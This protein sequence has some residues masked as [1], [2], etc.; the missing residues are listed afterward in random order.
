MVSPVWKG[1]DDFI[2]LLGA[3]ERQLLHDGL[4]RT[5]N[6]STAAIQEDA[7]ISTS[8]TLNQLKLVLVHQMLPFVGFGFLDNLIMILAGEYLDLTIGVTL[9][10]SVSPSSPPTH[11][12]I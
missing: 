4:S 1:V 5:L 6:E 9:G 12:Q 2:A 7:E 11:V 3:R 8:P 10:I